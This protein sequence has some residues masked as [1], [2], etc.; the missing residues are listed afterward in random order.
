MLYGLACATITYASA[1]CDP[2]LRVNNLIEV[3][4]YLFQ[5]APKTSANNIRH[6]YCRHHMLEMLPNTTTIAITGDYASQEELLVTQQAAA[7]AAQRPENK[8]LQSFQLAVETILVLP[9]RHFLEQYEKSQHEIA[10]KRLATE[11]V[12]GK[13]TEDTAME[14]DAE[15]AASHELLR[16]LIRKEVE[17]R[18][19]KYEELNRKYQTLQKE[20]QSR[21]TPQKKGNTRG[22]QQ[23]GASVNKK[24]SAN[25]SGQD[26]TM[27]NRS[28]SRNRSRSWSHSTTP[29][30]QSS[31]Q[32][33]QAKASGDATGND[34][35]GNNNRRRGSKQQSNLKRRTSNTGHNRRNKA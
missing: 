8:G 13:A 19:K 7:T 32:N 23:S 15:G 3:A 4:P 16:D 14:L 35:S 6:H 17:K 34:K 20:K 22:R 28:R 12:D 1:N 5:F 10:L 30:H 27:H 21:T 29:K 18:D 31:R 11:L 2:H 26:G 25:K 24:K 33:N 9:T